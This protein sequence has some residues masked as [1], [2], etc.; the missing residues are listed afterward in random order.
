[1][2]SFVFEEFHYGEVL[3]G[4]NSRVVAENF[5]LMYGEVRMRSIQCNMQVSTP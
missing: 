3:K 1:M 2:C 5:K 4:L